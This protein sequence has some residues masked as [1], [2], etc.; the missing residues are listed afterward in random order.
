MSPARLLA[1]GLMLAVL[2]GLLGWQVHRE[3]LVRACV[4]D[5]G[6]WHGAR[7]ECIRPILQR[8]YQRS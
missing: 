4:E 6:L 3:R 8:D 2:A 5:G 7:S 1:A